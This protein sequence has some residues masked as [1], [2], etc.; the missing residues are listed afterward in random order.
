MKSVFFWKLKT[1]FAMYRFTIL[2]IAIMTL[3]SLVSRSQAFAPGLLR[4]L[5]PIAGSAFSSVSAQAN[6]QQRTCSSLS[7][8]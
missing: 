4:V 5:T 1:E 8:R 2:T 6:S 3:L 7:M